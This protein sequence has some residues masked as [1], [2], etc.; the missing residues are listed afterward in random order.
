M[1]SSVVITILILSF[2][3]WIIKFNGKQMEDN[4]TSSSYDNITNKFYDVLANEIMII[5]YKLAIIEKNQGKHELDH[6]LPHFITHRLM[7]EPYDQ[8]FAWGYYSIHGTDTEP[9]E[10]F[11]VYFSIGNFFI[12]E[13]FITAQQLIDFYDEPKDC[14]PLK[15]GMNVTIILFDRKISNPTTLR[16]RVNSMILSVKK[17]FSSCL[18][19]LEIDI[20]RDELNDSKLTS[21]NHSSNKIIRTVA[22]L[23]GK[24]LF[25]EERGK[26]E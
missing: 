10:F 11:D 6:L 21:K 18:V 5:R 19:T 13:E 24:N 8:Q 23:S 1:S 17:D 22:L 15:Q 25:A 14:L 7:S 16:N 9:S 26:G 12:G 3:A 4:G 20:S 2:I